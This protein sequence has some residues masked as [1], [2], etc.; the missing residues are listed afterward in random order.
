MS[1]TLTPAPPSGTPAAGPQ[2]APN[3]IVVGMK[4]GLASF[5]GEHLD[6]L[7]Q[8]PLPGIMIFVHGVNSDGEWYTQTEE[9][10]C[11]GLN[12]R[13]ARNTDQLAFPTAEGGQ[14]VPARYISELTPNGF[15]N[16]DMSAKSFIQ[17]DET[18]TP[19]IRFRWGYKASAKE[20]QD[21]GKNIYL[22]EK[23]YW[24]GG[25]F[26]NG[27]TALPDLWGAGLDT[28]IAGPLKVQSVNPTN[29][30]YVYDCP[31]RAYYVLAALRLAKLVESL[32]K[33][34]ADLPITIVC[35]SQGNMIGMAAA[36]LGDK[37]YKDKGV[38]DTY[39]LC[40]PPYSLLD[41]NKPENFMQGNM[42]DAEGRSGRQSGAARAKTLANFFELIRQ[43]K[44][45]Q[46]SADSVDECM[47]NEAHGY[48]AKNDRSEHGYD[49]ST[50][51]RVTLYCN[52][53]DQ[54][55]S[56]MSV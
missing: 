23:D 11:R 7:R 44:S 40:N 45:R 10:L 20:L 54:V 27:C 37:L 16:P 15:I 41:E 12:K 53:H 55:I 3:N 14:L 24:G 51:G 46:Q 26:A 9:G 25:P 29:D 52:P 43:R 36:F 32:R 17:T 21:Y 28:G 4:C 19:V 35:H 42:K 34:Q 39:V 56:S 49:D 6:V 1:D 30:R 18:F 38:A 31:P 2:D 5:N 48:S 8:L 33:K 22:N 50:Y 13:L 47:A